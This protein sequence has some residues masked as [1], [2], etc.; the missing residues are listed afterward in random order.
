MNP[1][2]IAQIVTL[3]RRAPLQ[4]MAEAEAAAQLLQK[5]AAYFAKNSDQD[6]PSTQSAQARSE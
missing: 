5:L 2:E 4:N 3:A 6:S 1:Q